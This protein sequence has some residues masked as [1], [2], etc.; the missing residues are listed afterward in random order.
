MTVY[1]KRFEQSTPAEKWVIDLPHDAEFP[2]VVQVYNLSNQPVSWTYQVAVVDGDLVVDFGLDEV[3]GIVEYTYETNED[4]AV[5]PV[6][7]SQGGVINVHIHQYNNG[8]NDP[9]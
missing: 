4:L 3:A 1:H 6:I 8:L 2:K 9:K 7:G 5:D